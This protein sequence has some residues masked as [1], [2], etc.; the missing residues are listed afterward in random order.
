MA[1]T[2]GNPIAQTRA[3]SGARQ[4]PGNT[5]EMQWYP[6]QVE[7]L[8]YEKISLR[9]LVPL[10]LTHVKMQISTDFLKPEILS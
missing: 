6:I 2:L 9:Y 10:F 4:Y 8:H 1:L 5:P 3:A 7:F